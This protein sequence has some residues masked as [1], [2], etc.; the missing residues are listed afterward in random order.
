[1]AQF[2]EAALSKGQLRKLRALRKALG[3]EIADRAF[4]EWIQSAPAEISAQEDP[5]AKL[6][7]DS[8]MPLAASGKLRIPRG[9]YLLRRGHG[10]I[11]V[12]RVK[13]G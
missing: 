4:G 3:T 10:R 13:Q 8:L 2:D 11:I 6:I 1:M 12:E 9:G 7:S 5:T